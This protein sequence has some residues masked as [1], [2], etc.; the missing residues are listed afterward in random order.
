MKVEV[1][2][3]AL[4][5]ELSGPADAPVV[6]LSHSLACSKAMWRPQMAM[7][8]ERYR[9]LALAPRGHGHSDATP[10]PYSLDRASKAREI[11]EQERAFEL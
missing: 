4:H 3:A 1:D 5:Y 7:L 6:V 9:V 8:N 2:G 11:A 10:A